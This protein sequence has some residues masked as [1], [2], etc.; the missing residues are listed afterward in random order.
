MSIAS[1]IV[2]IIGFGGALLFLPS[3]KVALCCWSI[4]KIVDD[5]GWIIVYAKNR[6]KLKEEYDVEDEKK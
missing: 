5:I 3:L 2:C 1:G 6:E 4:C